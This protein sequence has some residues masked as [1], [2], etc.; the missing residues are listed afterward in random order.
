MSPT[1]NIERGQW[2]DGTVYDHNGSGMILFY[3]NLPEEGEDDDAEVIAM[4][5]ADKIFI[6]SIQTEEEYKN[7][8]KQRVFDV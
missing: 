5:P 4:Y 6:S 8:K 1:G 2:A 7:S 3:N